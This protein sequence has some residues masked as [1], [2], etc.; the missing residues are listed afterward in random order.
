MEFT[1]YDLFSKDKVFSSIGV[2][3]RRLTGFFPFNLLNGILTCLRSLLLKQ[4]F[5]ERL[6]S[7]KPGSG[8]VKVADVYGVLRATTE[9]ATLLQTILAVINQCC[10]LQFSSEMSK[11]APL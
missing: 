7:A 3:T 4:V 2:T 11:A 9:L 10:S 5:K 1:D 6:L 8:T